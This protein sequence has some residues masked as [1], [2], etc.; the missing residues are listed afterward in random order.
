MAKNPKESAPDR[1]IRLPEVSRLVGLSRS[2]IYRAEAAD[3]FPK[4]RRI[5]L[6]AVAWVERE[7][8]DWVASRSRA[9]A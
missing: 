4:R 2:A 1:L 5:G 3:D 7:V 6:R 9:E 8:R